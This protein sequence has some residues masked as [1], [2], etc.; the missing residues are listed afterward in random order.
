MRTNCIG[1]PEFLSRM[2]DHEFNM[3]MQ[4]LRSLLECVSPDKV[5]R[6]QRL[7]ATHRTLVDLAE[8]CEKLLSQQQH[9]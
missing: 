7:N 8:L 6:W 1:Y 2:E 3:H 5:C 4:P 9:K